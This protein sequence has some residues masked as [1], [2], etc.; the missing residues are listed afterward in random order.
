MVDRV[1]FFRPEVVQVTYGDLQ[2]HALAF[3]L[4]CYSVAVYDE[5]LDEMVID[6]RTEGGVLSRTCRT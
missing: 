4:S 5:A 2:T 3:L 6:S 1:L